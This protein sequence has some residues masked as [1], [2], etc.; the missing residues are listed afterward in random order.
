[1]RIED[2]VGHEA[3][4]GPGYVLTGPPL[5]ADTLLTSTR[6]QLVTNRRIPVQK[7]MYKIGRAWLPVR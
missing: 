1:V 2:D 6:G 7:Y 3:G 4:G 5:A